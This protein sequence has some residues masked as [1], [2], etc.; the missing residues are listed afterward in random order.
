LS[1]TGR[2]MLMSEVSFEFG[3]LA[4]AVELSH[5]AKGI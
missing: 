4:V 1:S 3:D 2:A 5:A